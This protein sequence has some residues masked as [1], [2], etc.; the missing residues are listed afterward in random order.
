LTFL[1]MGRSTISKAEMTGVAKLTPR[2][3]LHA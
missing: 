3:G 1:R 2:H